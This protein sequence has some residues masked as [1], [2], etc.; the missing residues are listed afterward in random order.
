[1]YSCDELFMRSLECYSCVYFPR[2]CATREIN[3]KITL[4]WA[5]KQFATRVH[6]LF[7][8]STYI[9]LIIYVSGTCPRFLSTVFWRKVYTANKKFMNGLVCSGLDPYCANFST[10]RCQKTL[11]Y[12][13]AKQVLFQRAYPVLFIPKNYNNP[14][15]RD[16]VYLLVK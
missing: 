11:L 8:A 1:M 13:S 3:N 15:H 5:H 7:Y 6:T 9:I 10:G 16:Y 14:V 12:K 4:S 2:Y